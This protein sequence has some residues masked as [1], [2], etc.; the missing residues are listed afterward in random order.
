MFSSKNFAFIKFKLSSSASRAYDQ[1]NGIM[2]ENN[3]IKI[4][5]ADLT[6][7]HN[8]TGDYE[9]YD[10]NENNCKTLFVAFSINSLI[11]SKE[12]LEQVFGEF[13]KV[14]AIYLK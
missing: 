12:K 11:P 5:F 1:A 8:I 13:G 14:R 4:S 9:G 3:Q 2:I 7:R 6:R 10:L